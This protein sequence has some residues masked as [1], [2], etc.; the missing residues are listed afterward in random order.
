M[1]GCIFLIHI[2]PL[3]HLGLANHIADDGYNVFSVVPSRFIFLG[4][5]TYGRAV[6]WG[7][8][9]KRLSIDSGILGAHADIYRR[10][11]VPKNQGL[12]IIKF[13]AQQP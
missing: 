8:G 7:L 6:G 3:F 11:L 13:W 1:K 12:Y 9:K 2:F 5:F 10:L 4:R